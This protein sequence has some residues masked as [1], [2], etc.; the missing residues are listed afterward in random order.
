MT[1]AEVIQM[2]SHSNCP[3]QTKIIFTTGLALFA[4]FFGAGNLAFPLHLGA[5]AGQHIVLAAIGFLL[6]GVGIPFLGLYA[7]SLYRGNYHDFFARIGKLPAFLMIT[8]LIINIGPLFAMP[9][10]EALTFSTLLPI[11]P[12]FLQNNYIF[13]AIYCGI[14]FLLAYRENK[15]FDI[16]GLVLSPIKIITFLS[17]IT[18]GLTFQTTPMIIPATGVEILTQSLETGYKTMDLL[19]TFFFCAVA[20]QGIQHAIT[21]KK[22]YIK[23]DTNKMIISA[24]VIG[25]SLIGIVY[26]GF[27]LVAHKHALALQGVDQGAVINALATAVLGNFGSLFVSVCVSFACLATALALAEVS[28]NYLHAEVFKGKVSKLT[29][30]ISIV[31]IMYAMSNLGFSKIVTISL[32]VLNVIYPTLIVLCVFNILYKWK[33][34]KT[35]KLPVAL[36]AVTFFSMEVAK[37]VLF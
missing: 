19:A 20:F 28:R 5:A 25:G 17:L 22:D 32:P 13:S 31:T 12:N 23:Y 37:H 18:I 33:G 27:M 7:T 29:C 9:R 14:V 4:M 6:A 35:V 2:S 21:Q 11:L 1:Q 3:S 36:T 30:L 16:L 24:C 34:I 10:T 26:V 15:I 8:F